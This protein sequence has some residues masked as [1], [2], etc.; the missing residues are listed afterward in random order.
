MS[1]ERPVRTAAEQEAV[2][3]K[4]RRQFWLIAAIF[5]IVLIGLTGVYVAVSSKVQPTT[6]EQGA[7]Q[8][9]D[10]PA[11]PIPDGGAEPTDSGDRGGSGQLALL[12]GIIVV[13]GAG[14]AWVVHSSRRAR[15]RHDGAPTTDPTSPV[16]PPAGT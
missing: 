7:A 1:T 15:R 12:G 4:D 11:L 5:A 6:P 9:V 2:D 14:A 13:L 3:R 16:A 8:Q 10:S